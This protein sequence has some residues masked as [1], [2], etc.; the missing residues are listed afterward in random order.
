MRKIIV[1]AGLLTAAA[2][3]TGAPA[4]A[5]LGCTCIK[6]GSPAMCTS[7]VTACT[8]QGGGVCVLPCDYT[9]AKMARHHRHHKKK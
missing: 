2:L 7:G 6:L 3:F 5:E 4:K 9:P 8:I 1:I